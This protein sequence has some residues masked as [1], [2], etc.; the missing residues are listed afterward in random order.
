MEL[1][2]VLHSK[3]NDFC[4]SIETI[5]NVNEV[6]RKRIT[7]T[8]RL[9]SSPLIS[10]WQAEFSSLSQGLDFT[11]ANNFPRLNT[12]FLFFISDKVL[13]VTIILTFWNFIAFFSFI[14]NCPI[15]GLR[16][17]IDITLILIPL[18]FLIIQFFMRIIWNGTRKSS[19]DS[20]V[21][22][23][24]QFSSVLSV[25]VAYLRSAFRN[26]FFSPQQQPI[27]E[28]LLNEKE[29]KYFYFYFSFVS[30]AIMAL[31]HIVIAILQ[32]FQFETNACVNLFF[33]SS[34]L[35]TS[36]FWSINITVHA[37][38]FLM[39]LLWKT[40]QILNLLIISWIDRFHVLQRLRIE[41]L[42]FYI[43]ANLKDM[44]VDEFAS[45]LRRDAFER[46]LLIHFLVQR[47][48]D[49][50]NSA[51][52][53]LSISAS[54]IFI[55]LIIFVIATPPSLWISSLIWLLLSVFLFFFPIAC[56]AYVNSAIDDLFQRIF[57][58]VPSGPRDE[59]FHCQT[60]DTGDERSSLSNRSSL[61]L[62]NRIS[63]CSATDFEVIGGREEW[64]YFIKQAPI[65]WTIYGIAITPALVQTFALGALTTIFV[66]FL[67]ILSYAIAMS[68]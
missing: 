10:D 59:D 25:A 43:P 37:S 63:M 39:A 6:E 38:V 11:L 64:I 22:F 21:P 2:N 18:V 40:S 29:S 17:A 65:H 13:F 42:S 48:S 8:K 19:G 62:L 60:L 5:P 46:Y 66:T 12:A 24:R 45:A 68:P 34:G 55:Y 4:P 3:S 54:I 53:Y 20:F 7:L 32:L 27:Y 67:P 28:K 31:A 56:V 14:G 16:Q 26:E 23:P 35:L 15:S 44:S 49:C 47:A 61:H 41:D 50:W 30:P 1:L 33:F 52:C 57:A 51:L 36:T 9:C 58:S